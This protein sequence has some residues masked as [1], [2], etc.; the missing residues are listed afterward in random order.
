MRRYLPE[1]KVTY[2]MPKPPSPMQWPQAWAAIT[3]FLN[4]LGGRKL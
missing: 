2:V 3:D 4:Q 1:R